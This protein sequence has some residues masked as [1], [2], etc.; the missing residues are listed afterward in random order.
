MSDDP[1]SLPPGLDLLW[2]RRNRGQRGPR[3]GLSVG[4]IVDA[5]I[6]IADAE[7]LSRSVDVTG[8]KRTRFH[9]DVAL[10]TRGEQG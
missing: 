3:P 5:A 1:R 9:P 2:G 10:P 8:G 4:A 7:G 6:A